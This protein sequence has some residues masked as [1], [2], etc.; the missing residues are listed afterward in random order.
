[1]NDLKSSVHSLERLVLVMLALVVI[2]IFFVWRV[3]IYQ[4]TVLDNCCSFIQQNHTL[5][6]KTTDEITQNTYEIEIIRKRQQERID[7]E[8]RER[9]AAINKQAK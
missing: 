5:L 2:H 8:A 4:N 6:L 7:R 3:H 9:A 1:M